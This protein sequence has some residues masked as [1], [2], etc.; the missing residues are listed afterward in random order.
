V[1][2]AL[3]IHQ[4]LHNDNYHRFFQLYPHTPNIGIYILDMMVD[5][6]RVKALQRMNRAYKP[7]I[8]VLFVLKELSFE[9]IDSVTST[10]SSSS[11]SSSIQSNVLLQ[12][13]H[14]YTP[15]KSKDDEKDEKKSSEENEKHKKKKHKKKANKQKEME[16]KLE[17]EVGH[18]I[19]SKHHRDH[20][21][22]HI[23][24]SDMFAGLQLLYK[25]GCKLY[26]EN[27]VLLWDTKNS[28]IRGASEVLGEEKLLL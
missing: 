10:S 26:E 5:S 21:I 11:G 14:T 17:K 3:S 6:V 19:E 8:E 1:Q 24:Q 9:L 16:L 4:A 22:E 12:L 28:T 13:V 27:N 18:D 7:N 20:V 23:I 25:A 2:H 15:I